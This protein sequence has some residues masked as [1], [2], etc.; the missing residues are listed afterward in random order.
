M[1]DSKLYRM[2]RKYQNSNSTPLKTT[3]EIINELIKG[4]FIL[5]LEVLNKSLNQSIILYT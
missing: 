5:S 4:L 3:N 2:I 1:F